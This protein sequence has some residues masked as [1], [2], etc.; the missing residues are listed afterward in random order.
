M[1]KQFFEHQIVYITARV[2]IKLHNTNSIG[3]GFFYHAPLND[4]TNRSVTLL[5]SNRHVFL[6]PKARL[7]I[8]LNR[9]K[10]DGTPEFGNIRT[11]DQVGFEDAYFV[12]P[13]SGVDLACINV[14][15]ITNTDAFYRNLGN[16]LLK[17][18]DYEKVVVGSEVIFVGYPENRYDVVNNLPLIRKGWIASMPNIDFNGKGQI[19]IDAQIFQGS[20]GSPV[21]VHWDGEYSLL[22]VVSQTMIRHSQL[23]TLPVNM[24]QV[25]V[26][27]TLGL[28]IVIKQRHVQELIDYVVNEYIQRTSQ[29]A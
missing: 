25:G 14:G 19:V 3:T 10:E 29:G 6:D 13:D 4:G 18:I 22:G 23:Q 20:S 28:G 11:F 7:I 9:R 12:H 21:F 8:S 24:P 1:A 2:E 27:Q 15:G 26:E 17:P 5:I 16:D